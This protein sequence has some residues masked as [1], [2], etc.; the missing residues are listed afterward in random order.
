MFD[1]DFFLSQSGA[2]I[3]IFLFLSLL[4]GAF[5]LPIPEDIPLMA[6]GVL[7]HEHQA[8]M[9]PIFIICYFGILIGDFVIYSAGRFFGPSLC[10][11]KWFQKKIKK[12]G[13][14]KVRSR[15]ENRRLLTI[16]IARHL[17]WIRTATFLICGLVR[18]KPIKFI[19]ADAIAALISIPIMISLGFFFFA[20]LEEML[21]HVKKAE[22]M[23]LI[24]LVALVAGAI[25]YKL[26]K[27]RTLTPT[28]R[29]RL[30][31]K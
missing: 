16:F 31:E 3:Y 24:V 26:R 17:F 25:L 20:R 12:I 13:L 27:K 5:G 8:K 2:N 9:L 22:G 21:G 7:L 28:K 10:R 30:E 29:C 1:F 4:A 23:I 6:A 18:I 19:I 11:T 14:K 15:L